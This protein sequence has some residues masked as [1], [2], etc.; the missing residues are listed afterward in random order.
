M[1]ELSLD[2]QAVGVIAYSLWE[3]EGRPDGRDLVH[4]EAAQAIHLAAQRTEPSDPLI[5]EAEAVVDGNPRADF[6]AL[7]TK[8]T[9]GG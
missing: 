3:Q 1:T 7:M 2:E 8:D 5:K 6:Q 9:S 4:W